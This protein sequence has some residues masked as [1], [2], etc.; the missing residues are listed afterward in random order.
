MAEL[1]ARI[2]NLESILIDLDSS[3]RSALAAREARERAL[4]TGAKAPLGQ[5]PARAAAKPTDADE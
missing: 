3:P 1:Q 5:L 2:E 4:G